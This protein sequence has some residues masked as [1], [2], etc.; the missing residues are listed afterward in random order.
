MPYKSDLNPKIGRGTSDK[1]TRKALAYWEDPTEENF[2][3]LYPILVGAARDV[4]HKFPLE[5]WYSPRGEKR[6]HKIFPSASDFVEEFPHYSFE[7]FLQE[8][9]LKV[10]I[11]FD[12]FDPS[13][14]GFYGWALMV[15]RSAFG[16][17]LVYAYRDHELLINVRFGLFPGDY[18]RRVE[19][20]YPAFQEDL[21]G[22]DIWSWH[23]KPRDLDNEAQWHEF[24]SDN[25]RIGE[26]ESK[27]LKDDIERS[28]AHVLGYSKTGLKMAWIL[29]Y[30]FGLEDREI[31][32][33][34]QC[35]EVLGSTREWVRQL[36]EKALRFLKHSKRSKDHLEEWFKEMAE[37]TRGL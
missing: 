9:I 2:D 5:V 10:L 3:E 12:S 6:R 23:G 18:H 34:N 1:I 8:G 11:Y 26:A 35:G 16:R 15:M 27:F 22:T 17:M 21:I 4:F 30:R 36:Q 33:L 24:F 13:R 25:G 32:T 31:R 29:R 14:G 28:F 20:L 37:G 7:D 19:H